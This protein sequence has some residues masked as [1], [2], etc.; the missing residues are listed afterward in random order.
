MYSRLRR[1]YQ[2]RFSP[3]LYCCKALLS[4]CTVLYCTLLAPLSVLLTVV[5]IAI[6]RYRCTLLRLVSAAY[7]VVHG[8]RQWGYRKGVDCGHIGAAAGRRNV[9]RGDTLTCFCHSHPSVYGVGLDRLLCT[10]HKHRGAP[11]SLVPSSSSNRSSRTTSALPSHAATPCSHSSKP[12]GAN[13]SSR[14]PPTFTVESS[15]KF[16]E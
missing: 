3:L 12:I 10:T 11:P 15:R 9:E 13:M 2:K 5:D 16:K 1:Y 14:R 8:K 4:V 6:A 7:T